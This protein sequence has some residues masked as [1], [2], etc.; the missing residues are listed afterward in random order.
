MPFLRLKLSW[1]KNKFPQIS[2]QQKVTIY[3]LKFL[4]SEKVRSENIYWFMYRSSLWYQIVS[5]CQKT[6]SL[7][8]RSIS[9]VLSINA[10]CFRT[11][12]TFENKTGPHFRLQFVKSTVKF[13]LCYHGY[14]YQPLTVFTF[15]RSYLLNIVQ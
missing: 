11:R 8:L 6:F 9:F 15:Q 4:S 12:F 10:T 3:L 1:R 7:I 13:A 2:S 5:F 14:S